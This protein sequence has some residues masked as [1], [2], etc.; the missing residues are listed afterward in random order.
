MNSTTRLSPDEPF[1]DDL[2]ELDAATVHVLHSKVLRELDAEYVRA[3]EPELE[4][5]SRLEELVEELDRR[6]AE[7]SVA[8]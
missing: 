4:T 6:E 7:D 8:E 3:G 1:P 2:R 5:E